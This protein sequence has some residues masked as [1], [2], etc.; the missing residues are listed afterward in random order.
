MKWNEK[1]GK[2]YL[3]EKAFPFGPWARYMRILG[4]ESFSREIDNKPGV[5]GIE[6]EIGRL[7]LD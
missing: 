3:G 1:C 2:R 6:N 5:R 4:N 7:K